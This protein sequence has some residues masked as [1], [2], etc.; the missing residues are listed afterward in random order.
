MQR[1]RLNK[2]KNRPTGG[3]LE[4]LEMHK[5]PCK[6][7]A[8]NFIFKVHLWG[9]TLGKRPLPRSI[10]LSLATFWRQPIWVHV[11]GLLFQHTQISWEVQNQLLNLDHQRTLYYM[12]LE[13]ETGNKN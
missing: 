4:V 2:T 6:L 7:L 3:M 9:L 5:D 13:E 12:H 10:P 8:F 1:D 11:L